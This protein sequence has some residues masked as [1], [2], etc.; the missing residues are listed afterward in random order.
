MSLDLAYNSQ[1]PANVGFGPG[2]RLNVQRRLALNADG[3]VTL[4]DADGARYTF[5]GPVT[6]GTVTTYTRPPALYATLVKDTG[7]AVEFTLTYRDQ[8]VD[9]FDTAGSEGLLTRAQDRF[10]NGVTLAYVAGTN[11]ISS[12]TDTAASP[13]RTI[14]FAYDGSNRL[15]SIT[16]WAYVL[17]RRRPD[18]RHGVPTGNPL[19]L[20]RLVQPVGLGRPAQ[21]VGLLPDGRQPSHLPHP[22][23]RLSSPGS[24]RPRP[25]RPWHRARWARRR[26][27]STPTSSTPAPT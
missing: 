14:D 23:G 19:L 18:D 26:A 22:H 4:T 25:T 27:P 7:Q 15:A 12:I 5:T 3:T 8:S 11:R 9:T 21:H 16:D 6:N 2:W 20:R 24:A 10:G 17:R 1:D 13:S